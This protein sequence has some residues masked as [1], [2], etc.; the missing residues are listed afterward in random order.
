MGIAERIRNRRIELGMTQEELAKRV[1]FKGKASINKIEIA[2]RGVPQSRVLD[3]ARALELSPAELLG[4][5]AETEDGGTIALSVEQRDVPI[6]GQVAAGKNLYAEENITGYVRVEPKIWGNLFALKVKGDSM[7]PRIMDGDTIIVREQ[8][9][10]ESGQIA[11]VIINGDE[12]VVK[13]VVKFPGGISLVSL[14]SS[15]NPL[16]FYNEEIDKLPIRI[17]GR[18]IQ[19][20]SD[21]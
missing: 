5:D 18:V 9:D 15:Y 17:I 2:G 16:I 20:R 3:F 21:F 11:V 7:S 12:G 4:W 14:N 8:T 19:N 13:K 10:V 1:G 6:L